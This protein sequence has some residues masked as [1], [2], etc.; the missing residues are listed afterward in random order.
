MNI[1]NF[2][3]QPNERIADAKAHIMIM[4]VTNTKRHVMMGTRHS[5]TIGTANRNLPSSYS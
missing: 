5:I 3:V 1:A 4:G 2:V